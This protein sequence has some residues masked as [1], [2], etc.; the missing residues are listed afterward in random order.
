MKIK[1]KQWLENRAEEMRKQAGS[2]APVLMKPG[3]DP[4]SQGEIDTHGLPHL[5]PRPEWCL[6]CAMAYSQQE[7][8]KYLRTVDME[9][10]RFQ[11]DFAYFSSNGGQKVGEKPAG[12]S[13]RDG[14]KED[15]V[16]QG[17]LQI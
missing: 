9:P 16:Q 1:E 8:H 7:D 14:A 15:E 3:V 5:P 17:R 10:P 6:V 2:Q 12:V 13:T 11:F 4:P